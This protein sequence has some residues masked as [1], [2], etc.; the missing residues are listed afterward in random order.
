M[1]NDFDF[2]QAQSPFLHTDVFAKT[3]EDFM[4]RCAPAV[5]CNS[6]AKYRTFDGSCNNIETP[7]WGAT[8]TPFLRL[9]DAEY[10][11]GNSYKNN[12]EYR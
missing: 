1:Y 2:V 8:N 5:V 6:N 9:H 10:S 3:N 4:R 7:T 12:I 11:D